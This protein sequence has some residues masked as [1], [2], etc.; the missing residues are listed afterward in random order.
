MKKENKSGKI[1]DMPT[2]WINQS[3]LNTK[4][5]YLWKNMIFRTTQKCW[6]ENP[7]YVG[8]TVDESWLKLSNFVSDIKELSGYNEWVNSSKR[9]MMLDKDTLVE[10]NKHY[11][12]NTCCF[13]SSLESSLDVNKR[14]P[15]NTEKAIRCSVENNSMPVKFIN[16]TSKEEKVF[17]SL[18]EACR[19]MN[20]NERNSWK[21]LSDKYPNCHS[22]KGWEI[23]YNNPE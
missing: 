13:I 11:S 1:N 18:K 2:G 6:D 22:I 4:I 12:K 17:P 21:V 3:E 9:M 23:Q 20:I 19:E 16:K 15:N 8:T 7:T 5:Y 14:H 10:G